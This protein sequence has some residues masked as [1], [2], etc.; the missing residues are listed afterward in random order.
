MNELIQEM[1][2]EY[3][4]DQ[5]IDALCDGEFLAKT[6]L[7]DDEVVDAYNELTSKEEEK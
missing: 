2:E 3:P 1:L 6:G 7:T 5:V 4:K